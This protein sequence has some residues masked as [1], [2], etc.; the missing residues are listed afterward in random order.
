MTTGFLE[1]VFFDEEV[2]RFFVRDIG[3]DSKGKGCMAGLK[4][5]ALD[6]LRRHLLSTMADTADPGPPPTCGICGS[7]SDVHFFDHVLGLWRARCTRQ[8]KQPNGNM[9]RAQHEAFSRLV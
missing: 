9:R 8:T 4:L 2:D 6:S 1:N 5:T 3:L 7:E